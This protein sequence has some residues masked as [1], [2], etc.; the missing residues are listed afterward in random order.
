M[1]FLIITGSNIAEENRQAAAAQDQNAHF[2]Q[3]IAAA[4]TQ[5][6][7][8]IGA[9]SNSF[10]SASIGQFITPFDGKNSKD[11]HPWVKQVEKSCKLT[12]VGANNV[13]LVAYNGSRDGLSNFLARYMA[14][15]PNA[16]WDM[17]KIEIVRKVFN[18]H[19]SFACFLFIKTHSSERSRYSLKRKDCARLVGNILNSLVM[20]PWI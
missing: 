1:S 20:N 8:Q 10:G 14:Q 19:R 11:F 16:T 4:F 12:D 15:F 5:L 9:L 7:A 17:I 3:E 18:Y 2:Q 6:T 13:K